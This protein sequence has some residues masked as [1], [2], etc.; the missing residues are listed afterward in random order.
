M[1]R[2]GYNVITAH[3]P[4]CARP[5]AHIQVTNGSF[6]CKTCLAKGGR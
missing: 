4:T 1:N 6:V 2:D 3:C 5:S